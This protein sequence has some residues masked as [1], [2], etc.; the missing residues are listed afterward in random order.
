MDILSVYA[1]TDKQKF[2]CAYTDYDKKRIDT[3]FFAD[4][5]V[6]WK[7]S[8]ESGIRETYNKCHTQFKDNVKYYTEFIGA[9]NRM[10]WMTYEQMGDCAISR[11]FNELWSKANGYGIDHFEGDDLDFMYMVLD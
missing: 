9:L 6:A 3:T 4:L 8:G 11:L 1:T 2:P 10:L 7:T 5:Y